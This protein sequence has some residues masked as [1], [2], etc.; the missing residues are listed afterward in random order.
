MD[1]FLDI[2]KYIDHSNLKP[3]ATFE[4][5]EILCKEA[6][7]YRFHSVC[8]NPFYV[9]YAKTMLNGSN[10]KVCSVVGFPLGA[11]T[12]K[13]KLVEASTAINDGADELDIVWNIGAFKSGDYSFVENELKTIIS[14][15]KDAVHKIIVE[16]AYLSE[17]EKRIALDIVINAGAE[18][19][20]TSTSFAPSGAKIEDIKLWKKIADGKIKIKAAG[21]IR[22]YKT[23]VEMIKAGA[24]RIGSSHSIDIIKGR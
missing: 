10:V 5:I 3:Y 7:H 21:G 2:S 8:V 11:N 13:T 6:V 9:K 14:Y 1:S 20:K 12:P 22:D 24:D 15:T 16:T 23:A 17:E 18:F 19:I 4:D